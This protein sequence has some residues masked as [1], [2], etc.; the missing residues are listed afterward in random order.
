M[1]QWTF[2]PLQTVSPGWWVPLAAVLVAVD[3]LTGPFFQF[4]SVYILVVAGA[5][6]FSGLT[7]GLVLAVV[8]PLSRVVLM[9]TV[10]DE[11]WDAAVFIATAVTRFVVFSVM[12]VLVARLAAHERAMVKEVRVLT[13]LLPVCT[14][15]RKIRRADDGWTSLE[16]YAAEATN[17]FAV[18]MCPDCATSHL[19]EY[20]AVSERPVL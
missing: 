5:A 12:A 14:Y 1:K 11:P 8:M 17:D 18:G 20:A 3:Y 6:W 16:A 15:C 4:P 19:P 10:W 9:L 2:V 13:S 7:A